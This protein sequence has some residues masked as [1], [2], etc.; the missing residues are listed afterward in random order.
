M[1][2]RP[3]RRHLLALACFGS[4]LLAAG[5]LRPLN[6]A[7][8]TSSAWVL[9]GIGDSLTH[10]TMDVVVNA[11]NTAN[12]YLQRVRNSLVQRIPI[13]FSQ[14]FLDE[15]GDRESPF[16]VPTN[17]AVSGED[18]F[19]IEG[20]A[21]YKRAGTPTSLISEDLLADKLLPRQFA[22]LHDKVLYP[23]NVLARQPVSQMESAEWLLTQGMPSAGLDHALIVYWLGNNDSSTA[24]LGEG[25]SNPMFLPL[26]V[27]QL[28]PVLPGL[29][30][31][32]K[33]GEA[34]GLLS[35]EPYTASAI[36]RNLTLLADFVDQQTRNLTRIV[37]A[38]GAIERHIFVLTLP[39]YSAVGYLFDSEDLEYYLKKVN[40]AYSVPPTFKRVAPPGEPITDPLQGDRISLLTFGMMYA[41]LDSGFSVSFVNGVLEQNGQQRDGM[42]LSEA[43]V[44]GIMS[45]TDGFNATLKAVAAS[46]GPHVH[47][48]DIGP[49]LSDVLTGEIDLV[50]GGRQIGRKW[51]RGNA[52]SFDGVHPG[53]TGQAFVANYVLE[54]VSTVLGVD[55][56]LADL[57]AVMET[58]PYIDRD[59]D[60]W[61]AGPNYQNAGIGEVLF[62]FKDPDDTNPAAQVVLPEDV[63]EQIARAL[64][65]EVVGL[66]PAMRAEAERLGLVAR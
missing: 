35:F 52:F 9:I 47:V 53:Y 5:I 37:N 7:D 16:H 6:A 17:L 34:L 14:P 50:I 60:G 22:D 4:V 13:A 51:I 20:L 43:E 61:A 45:R 58:D 18:S 15:S 23:V 29:S 59:G 63:W 38:A 49:H 33:F 32:L 19:S 44:A 41:L 27:D 66:S 8:Q 42:V 3:R 24:A 39:Y 28:T 46:V 65:G 36:D 25:G 55:A 48:V 56:P 12:A 1:I 21:Y 2:R 54:H 40:P 10:G 57:A 62:L 64:L 11:I 31:L 30:T 26:P